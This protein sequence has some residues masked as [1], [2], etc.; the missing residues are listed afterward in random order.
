M[1]VESDGVAG[2]RVRHTRWSWVAAVLVVIALGIAVAAVVI[3][4]DT[5]FDVGET[6]HAEATVMNREPVLES[7]WV[8]VVTVDG[9][10][11]YGDDTDVPKSWGKGPELGTVRR[12]NADEGE[13]TSDADGQTIPISRFLKTSCAIN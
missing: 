2:A 5:E 7:C 13:F 11:A 6:Q 3:G 10:T 1:S 4:E 9:W 8:L 12:I